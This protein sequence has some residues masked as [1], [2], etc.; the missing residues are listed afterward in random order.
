MAE[1][2]VFAFGFSIIETKP[3]FALI[4]ELQAVL[5]PGTDGSVC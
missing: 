3:E 1:E 4:M 2:L 5:M